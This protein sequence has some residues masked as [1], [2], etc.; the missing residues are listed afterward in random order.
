MW[1]MRSNDPFRGGDEVGTG[2]WCMHRN[3]LAI[4]IEMHGWK[5]P[6]GYVA[7]AMNEALD[8]EHEYYLCGDEKGMRKI[9]IIL[10]SK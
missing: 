7:L 6:F 8:I 2:E 1:K 3:T 10:S 9:K 5:F 4:A